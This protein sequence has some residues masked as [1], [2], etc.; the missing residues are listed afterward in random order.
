MTPRVAEHS[1][2]SGAADSAESIGIGG[3]NIGDSE[4]G[5][6]DIATFF[7][8]LV[9]AGGYPAGSLEA[10]HFPGPTD[11]VTMPVIA[12]WYVR[13]G[14]PTTGPIIE[15]LEAF[16]RSRRNMRVNIPDLMNVGWPDEPQSVCM[17]MAINPASIPTWATLQCSLTVTPPPAPVHAAPVVARVAMGNTVDGLA[18]SIHTP[19]MELDDNAPSSGY[20]QHLRCSHHQ[21]SV[22]TGGPAGVPFTGLAAGDSNTGCPK[23]GE[24]KEADSLG[25]VHLSV[26]DQI[27]GHLITHQPVCNVLSY[28]YR[29]WTSLLPVHL[30]TLLITPYKGAVRAQDGA[31]GGGGGVK[32]MK[33]PFGPVGCTV[34]FGHALNR[35]GGGGVILLFAMVTSNIVFP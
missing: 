22:G 16:G 14:I 5:C 23:G 25:A 24:C 18:S 4:S 19:A 34:I 6:T 3:G 11:N 27:D 15:A 13:H 9:E 8:F 26:A 2:V 30:E 35:R 32:C 20:K 10:E 1:E 29:D 28:Q 12:A 17:A 33:W 21:R 31:R 7:A